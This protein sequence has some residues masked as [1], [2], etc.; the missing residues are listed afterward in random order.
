MKLKLFILIIALLIIGYNIK[1]YRAIKEAKAQ[2]ITAENIERSDKAYREWKETPKTFTGTYKSF[3][4]YGNIKSGFV[5]YGD[6]L[7]EMKARGLSNTRILDLLAIKWME[8]NSYKGCIWRAWLDMWPFQIN[9]VHTD[10]YNKSWQLW[11]AK[12]YWKLFNYQLSF[13]N[14]LIESYEKRFCGEHIFKKIWRK[15]TNERRFKCV[16]VSYNGHPR[17]KH[18]YKKIWWE[19]RKAIS[20]FLFSNN[21][22]VH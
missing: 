7:E 2:L 1:E 16:A 22:L 10:V 9:K 4:P 6:Q 17:Y 18:T 11:N 13:A 20:E 8:C 14:S 12:E 19:K 5:V 21:Y 3:V 15:Y